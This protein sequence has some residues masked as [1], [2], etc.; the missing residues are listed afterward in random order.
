[1]RFT[2]SCSVLLIT[3]VALAAGP[4]V[5]EWQNLKV[6]ES[7]NK[8]ALKSY[9]A[10]LESEC[11]YTKSMMKVSQKLAAA[12]RPMERLN[13]YQ[14]LRYVDRYS[15]EKARKENV[16]LNVVFQIRKEDYEVPVSQRS[17][18]VWDN[19]SKGIN[20]LPTVKQQLLNG[21]TFNLEF[22]KQIHRSFY[23]ADESGEY[24]MVLGPGTIKSAKDAEISWD[25]K[26][27]EA[28][29]SENVDII[30]HM[31]LALGLE[32]QPFAAQGFTQIMVVQEGKLKPSH[33][34]YS[35]THIKNLLS[36][37]DHMVQNIRERKPLVW[38]GTIF[39]PREL[40]L[41]VQ[42]TIVRIHGFHDGNG[43][44]SRYMQD[45]VLALFDMPFMPSGD[46]QHD[47]MTS[48]SNNYYEAATRASNHQVQALDAC[49]DQS[50][51]NFNCQ[52]VD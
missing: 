43:R 11:D 17:H 5:C 33:P 49:R 52:F 2:V 31:Y 26:T 22:F 34:A 21:Q 46:L 25:L 48:L 10:K 13:Y 38:N 3:K 41:F 7:I 45:L 9:Y 20:T 42:Q 18:L 12:G 35:E 23:T 30:N 36:F 28:Q 51:Q 47:D 14:G 24:G 39:T 4:L 19:W 6:T 44:T 16:P 40:A 15:F 1:M 50:N 8:N 37:L 27:D 32:P 29:I